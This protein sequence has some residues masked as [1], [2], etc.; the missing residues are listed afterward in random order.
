MELIK[1]WSFSVLLGVA[2]CSSTVV[3]YDPTGNIIGSCK[4]TRG[5][6][7]TASASCGGSGNGLGIDY[8]RVDNDTGLLPTPPVHQKIDLTR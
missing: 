6:L 5:L 8:N 7:S 4:A 3:T 2:G 1:L